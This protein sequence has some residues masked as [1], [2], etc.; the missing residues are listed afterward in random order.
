MNEPQ[1]DV[2]YKRT[3]QFQFLES[4][5]RG[6]Q[7]DRLCS[8]DFFLNIAFIIFYSHENNEKLYNFLLIHL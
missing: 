2:V 3:K 5:W 4:F 1:K 8:A 7:H 6:K